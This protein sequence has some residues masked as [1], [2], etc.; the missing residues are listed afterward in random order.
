MELRERNVKEK[1]KGKK[2]G[3]GERE[4]KKKGGMGKGEEYKE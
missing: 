3:R 1:R 2:G 4:T